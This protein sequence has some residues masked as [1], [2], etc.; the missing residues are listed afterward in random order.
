MDPLQLGVP[1][2]GVARP[3]HLAGTVQHSTVQGSSTWA[4]NWGTRW[5]GR[6]SSWQGKARAELQV[7]L[8]PGLAEST[9]RLDSTASCSMVTH[10]TD[11]R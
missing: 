8:E 2:Q 5:A 11:C 7:W 9:R 3:H 10:S 4:R 1:G 6:G